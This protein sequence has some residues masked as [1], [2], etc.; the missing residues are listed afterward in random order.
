M[1]TFA[2][3]HRPVKILRHAPRHILPFGDGILPESRETSR[4]EAVG[5]GPLVQWPQVLAIA[6]TPATGC[7][8][9]EW[10]G[11]SQDRGRYIVR[12]YV[13]H[14]VTERQTTD[15]LG[16]AQAM[17][18]HWSTP[19]PDSEETLAANWTLPEEGEPAYRESEFSHF[20]EYLLPEPEPE[21]SDDHN[22][23]FG[24]SCPGE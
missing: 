17:F 13:D 11:A 7:D 4:G 10:P 1:T 5:L 9:L 23:A 24:F 16:D 15:S 21:L 12:R 2:R 8:L 18:W 20:L 22:G 19:L 3:K 6:G 14:R